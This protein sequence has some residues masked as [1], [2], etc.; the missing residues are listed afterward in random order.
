MKGTKRREDT[1]LHIVEPNQTLRI[2]GRPRQHAHCFDHSISNLAFHFSYVVRLRCCV[3][4]M[5]IAII[6][7]GFSLACDQLGVVWLWLCILLEG[8]GA[9]RFRKPPET[10]RRRFSKRP[11]ETATTTE[12][13]PYY[14]TAKPPRLRAKGACSLS[15]K[16]TQLTQSLNLLFS[17]LS[18]LFIICILSIAQL[19]MHLIYSLLRAMSFLRIH[20]PLHLQPS[21]YDSLLGG[22][23]RPEP[24]PRRIA[25]ARWQQ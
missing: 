1:T 2:H 23:C 24:V 4:I 20:E 8:P 12:A 5:C 3:C 25:S 18:Y 14:R 19:L 17:R 16:R 6:L 22:Q 7:I 10:R 21:C 9:P 13:T 15:F 11:T